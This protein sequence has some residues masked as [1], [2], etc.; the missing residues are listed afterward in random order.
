MCWT[1]SEMA[2]WYIYRRIPADWETKRPFGMTTLSSEFLAQSTMPL[3]P[4]MGKLMSV[5][6]DTA[7]SLW[8]LATAEYKQTNRPRNSDDQYTLE[9]LWDCLMENHHRSIYPKSQ[10]VMKFLFFHIFPLSHTQ[11]THKLWIEVWNT[12]R[13]MFMWCFRISMFMC[14]ACVSFLNNL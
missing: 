10:P 8:M 3:R 6:T 2:L 12:H 5:I 7:G 13:W 1:N 9:N 4:F 14:K 11:V